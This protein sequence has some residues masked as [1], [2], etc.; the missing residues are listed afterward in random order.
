MA[1][2]MNSLNKPAPRW[3]RISKKLISNTI[4]FAMAILLLLGYTDSSLVMLIIKLSQSFIM[5][6]LETFM[7][8]GEV[9]AEQNTTTVS[10]TFSKVAAPGDADLQ[11]K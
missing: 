7:S 3:L 4:N 6:Q 11:N 1:I 5:D 9:Y 8:N 2:G 10:A